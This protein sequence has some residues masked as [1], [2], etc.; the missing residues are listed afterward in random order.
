MI[1]RMSP[2]I[3]QFTLLVSALGGYPVALSAVSYAFG[4]HPRSSVLPILVT[5]SWP[6]MAAIESKERPALPRKSFALSQAVCRDQG[7]MK[8]WKLQSLAAT[9]MGV[10]FWYASRPGFM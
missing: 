1:E 2:A 5:T 10:L 6:E 9:G 8:M 4:S 3:T 7:P